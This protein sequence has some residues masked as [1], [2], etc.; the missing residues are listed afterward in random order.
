MA[1]VA[2]Q[3]T[4][5]GDDSVLELDEDVHDLE[6]GGEGDEELDG[7]ELLDACDRLEQDNL[8]LR[9]RLAK[10]QLHKFQRE[11][12]SE[13]ENDTYSRIPQ[14]YIHRPRILRSNDYASQ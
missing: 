10:I 11:H 12:E 6:E 1:A 5:D 13:T 7:A 4:H 2:S 14:V 9:E 8:R 3:L